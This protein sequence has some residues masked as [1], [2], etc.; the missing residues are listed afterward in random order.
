M[1]YPQPGYPSH[2]HSNEH[3]Q[4]YHDPEA[5]GCMDETE[6][7]AESKEGINLRDVS[8]FASTA[9]S[10]GIMGRKGQY[11]GA[12]MRVAST[13]PSDKRGG[14]LGT[15]A[16]S[17]LMGHKAR[18]AS[19]ATGMGHHKDSAGMTAQSVLGSGLC[20]RKGQMAAVAMGVAKGD[21]SN[22]KGGMLGKAAASGLLGHKGRMAA[23]ATGA[24]HHKG[25]SG[26]TVQS[27][28]G[29]GLL[30]SKGIVAGAAM[31]LVKGA[32]K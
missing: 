10:S 25:N 28:L 4:Y 13:D 24:G 20:G 31:D 26:M 16:A 5:D 21:S 22:T 15:V 17:G 11:A 32:R 27:V 14:V 8:R 18:M 9:L 7:R 12:A 3:P 1:P 19:H 29:S 30:G 23:H 6:R 2:I